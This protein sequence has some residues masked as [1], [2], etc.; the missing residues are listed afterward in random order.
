MLR[1]VAC[2]RAAARTGIA[3]AQGTRLTED[4]IGELLRAERLPAGYRALIEDL[5]APLAARILAR[6]A[7]R[8]GRPWIVGLCGPQGSGKS[9]LAVSLQHL[10]E[11]R[12]ARAAVL[13]LDDLYLTRAG[14]ALLARRVHPLLAT[15][16]VPGT[17]DVAL[18]RELIERLHSATTVALPV[19]DKGR[20]DRLPQGA[21]RSVPA[22][23][24]VLLFEGWCV[25]ARPQEAAALI[26]PINALER[27]EDPQGIWRRYVNAA[28]A[29]EYQQLFAQLDQLIML[30][31]TGFEQV[32]AWRFEQE[33]KLR[34]R[35]QAAGAD[36]SATMDEVQ[37]A[38]FV[39]LFE[40]LTRHMLAEMPARADEVLAARPS[41]NRHR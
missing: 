4:W 34:G 24:D 16:G 39:Q 9:T 1:G 25:G 33:R 41:A 11:A 28:L 14:R 15:R 3:A 35:L 26:E 22:P 29:G 27:S 8:A 6:A 10:I 40:R 23:V 31:A 20:D 19:F 17:H 5:H 30:S 36:A 21:W 32:Y 13:S 38:R 7:R 37:L 18:G 12:G 2:A